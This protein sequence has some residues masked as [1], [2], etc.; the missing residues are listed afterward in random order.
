MKPRVLFWSRYALP[1]ID[2]QVVAPFGGAEFK[3][4]TVARTL[5]V[6]GNVD[7]VLVCEGR[8]GYRSGETYEVHGI[9]IGRRTCPSLPR[10]MRVLRD[11]WRIHQ[12]L[13][14]AR[15]DVIIQ[16][17]A[18]PETLDMW[19]AGRRFGC[20]CVYWGASLGDFDGRYRDHQGLVHAASYA[21]SLRRVD[22]VVCQT[23]EQMKSLEENWSRV[24]HLIPNSIQ[25]ADNV[26]EPGTRDRVVWIGK[27]HPWKGPDRY[28]ELARCRP[29]RNFDMILSTGG[30]EEIRASILE[31]T[32][33]VSNLTVHFDVPIDKINDFLDRA[34]VLVNT[35]VQEGF[36]NAMLQAG[37]RSVPTLSLEVDPDGLL[38]REIMGGWAGCDL[39]SLGTLVDA[40]FQ[41]EWWKE[42]SR[43]AHL[44]VS[45]NHDVRSAGRKLEGLLLD[46]ISSR[47]NA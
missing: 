1:V 26:H 18:G 28:V 10:P 30:L 13:I 25:V 23:S 42:H 38:S 17:A 31:Q 20:P 46:L 45:E 24:G 16:S 36:P 39:A 12:A 43:K 5:A 34:R 7:P 27:W 2:P 29:G 47:K 35:S 4:V 19:I 3:L 37:A 9:E 32:R 11:R 33:S 40:S 15:P 6:Q 8:P 22:A 44:H 41:D 21:Y 14:D